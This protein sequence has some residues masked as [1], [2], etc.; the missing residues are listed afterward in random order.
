MIEKGIIKGYPLQSDITLINTIYIRPQKD[1]E[2]GKYGSDYLYLIY[3][4]N[5]TKEK[6]FQLIENPYYTYFK[7]ND[8]IPANYN[9]LYIERDKVH[10][11]K[12]KYT[13]L[14]RSIAENTNNLDWF[15]DNLKT[16]NYREN[17]KLF[18]I[19]SIFL[20]D[21]NIE[22]YYR[23]IFSLQYKNTTFN[24]SKL[25]FD[26]ETDI[27]N[28]RG[29]FP[30]P[31]ECPVNACT[32]VDDFNHRIY[33]LLLENYNNPLIEDFKNINEVTA[34]LKEFVKSRVGGWKNEKRFGLD[35]FQYKIAFFDE[36]KDLLKTI[37]DLINYIKPDFALAWNIA[38]D[39]PYLIQRLINL[40]IDPR[41]VIC[42]P[43]MPVKYCDY[44]IDR[45]ADKFEERGDY[46][47]IT[48]YT[49]YIDQLI[50][51]AS[52]R[53]GQR[54]VQS[55]KLDYIGDQFAGV[56][57]LDYSHITTSIA[58]L[59]Y[60]DYKT[61]VF[62]NCMDTIVQLCVEHNV[63]DV[64]FLFNKALTNNTR[65]AK[66][67]RQTTYLVNRG[68]K[69]FYNMGYIMGN[70]VNKSNP[71]EGFPGAFV[72]DPVNVSNKPK[73]FINGIPI[74]VLK[75]LD[76]FDYSALYPS[77][78]EQ[79]NMSPATMYGKIFLD[80]LVDEKE[81]RFNNDNFDRTI[82][83]ME[84]LISG[85]VLDFCSRYLHL[86]GYEQMYDDVL[87]YYRTIKNPARGI[88]PFDTLR[89]RRIM[90]HLVPDNKKKRQMYHLVDN[91]NKRRMTIL[92]ERMPSYVNNSN[93]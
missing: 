41:T 37:F 25:Y 42:H 6:K 63:G 90:Y 7:V 52:R 59:P 23:F 36:E 84:D 35:D 12:C 66:V 20:A 19:P 31:G 75:N 83:F 46:S 17:D 71:K 72:A 61:F 8:N 65:Y 88:T 58:K 45:R 33:V 1:P 40:G 44:F 48:S 47:T 78:I 86:A 53:K 13:D 10:P 82:W 14:K 74:N 2:T 39:L 30:E 5:V 79:S 76:D 16:G 60:L 85:N 77:I 34:E 51:F 38:F 92:C 87:N 56:R 26:I 50:T 18:S 89:G 55:F 64:D 69:D 29:D 67:H 32:I 28:M 3:R 49:V 57:K 93:S 15:Y 91:T 80:E 4:D 9:K 22:D 43:D 68:I 54:S 81:N 62:Y 21:V 11:I 73:M 27:I 24:P 70:N